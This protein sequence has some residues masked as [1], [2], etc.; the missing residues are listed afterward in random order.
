MV[1]GWGTAPAL[2][3]TA[4]EELGERARPEQLNV[5]VRRLQ[6][7]YQTGGPRA[8]LDLLQ[9]RTRTHEVRA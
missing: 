8:P 4:A 2:R 5:E 9:L 3:H 7:S 1:V 6:N